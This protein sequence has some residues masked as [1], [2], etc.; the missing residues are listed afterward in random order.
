MKERKNNNFLNCDFLKRVYNENKNQE[1]IIGDNWRIEMNN[2]LV[3]CVN[4]FAAYIGVIPFLIMIQLLSR[5]FKLPKRHQ[6]GLY[7]YS[8]TICFILMSTDTPSL[9]QIHFDPSFNLIPFYKFADNLAE[10]VQGFIVFIPFGMLLPTLWE[11]FRSL[12]KTVFFGL[13]FSFLVEMSQIF[14]LL[15]TATTDITYILV[16]VLGTAAGYFLFTRISGLPFMGRMCLTADDTVGGRLSGR[17]ACI[18]F[19]T[20]WLVTFLLS[21]FISNALWDFIWNNAVGMSI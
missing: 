14:C 6:F 5:K 4:T 21:P 15:T 19:M 18:Y 13:L 12:K 11:Q 17:E 7:L 9:Y 2:F 16:N 3:L 20:P 1:F 8:L 10:Y